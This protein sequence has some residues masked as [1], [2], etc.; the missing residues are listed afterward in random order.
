[1]HEPGGSAA[2]RK[3]SSTSIQTETSPLA[4]AVLGL[5][6]L[7]D[8]MTDS[9]SVFATPC[10]DS[11]AREG[12]QH[13]TPWC[14]AEHFLYSQAAVLLRIQTQYFISSTQN[15]ANPEPQTRTLLKLTPCH[16]SVIISEPGVRGS[17]LDCST[18]GIPVRTP[19]KDL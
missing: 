18:F 3:L 16:A 8:A 11:T 15:I 6:G 10:M 9:V 7:A 13:E 17:R 4:A 2:L 5:L 19:S 14:A 1:M 12:A